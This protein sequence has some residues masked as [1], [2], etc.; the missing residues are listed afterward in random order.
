[1]PQNGHLIDDLKEFFATFLPR[2]SRAAAAQATT[3]ASVP[4]AL[5]DHGRVRFDAGMQTR[6][7]HIRLS[8]V[9]HGRVRF[10]AGMV[11]RAAPR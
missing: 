10:G 3:S 4:T 5:T 6:P 8:V 9:D 7:S 2:G 1:M 11:R